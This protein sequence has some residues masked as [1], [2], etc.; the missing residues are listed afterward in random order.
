MFNIIG[1]FTTLNRLKNDLKH[2]LKHLCKGRAQICQKY[3]SQ[4]SKNFEQPPKLSN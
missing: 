4:I 2:L 3:N 1:K